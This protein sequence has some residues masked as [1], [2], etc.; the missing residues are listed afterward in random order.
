MLPSIITQTE[1][2][3]HSSRAEIHFVYPI[4]L[5]L[6]SH[7]KLS[8]AFIEVMQCAMSAITP[9]LFV[10][11]L[12]PD[13]SP[14]RVADFVRQAVAHGVTHFFNCCSGA[15]GTLIGLRFPSPLILRITPSRH[16]T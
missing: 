9:N 7:R 1:N 12:P 5:Q 11:A 14:G 3:E 8:S 16:L 4:Q 2:S 13:A 6:R 10:G 15:S